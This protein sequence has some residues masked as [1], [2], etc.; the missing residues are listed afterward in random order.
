[1][2]TLEVRPLTA[3]IGAEVAG[4]SLA[5]ALEE[6]TIACIRRALL[7][8]LVLFFRDQDLTDEQ[9]LDFALRFGPL[10]L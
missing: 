1:M 5:D 10:S 7:D 9:H 4:V 8:H 6:E 3:A 2:P